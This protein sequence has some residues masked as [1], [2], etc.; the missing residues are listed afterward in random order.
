[1]I[2]NHFQQP[3]RIVRIGKDDELRDHSGFNHGSADR[4]RN[5]AVDIASGV[6]QKPDQR[7]S[8]RGKLRIDKRTDATSCL[9]HLRLDEPFD[10]TPDGHPADAE[11]PAERVFGR[12]L[13]I[14]F[15]CVLRQII[16]ICSHPHVPGHFHRHNVLL[17][18]TTYTS[19]I[20][21]NYTTYTSICQDPV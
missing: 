11:H 18:Y 6:L 9:K 1:M 8:D 5:H 20:C 19:C 21:F 13:R 2:R 17:D 12:N 15:R 7:K 10:R 4:G 16:E 14:L 3:D